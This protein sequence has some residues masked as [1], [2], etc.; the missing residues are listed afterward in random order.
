MNVVLLIGSIEEGFTYNSVLEFSKRSNLYV[1]HSNKIDAKYKIKGVKFN[2]LKN[3][4]SS[5][6]HF[7]IFGIFIQVLK[8]LFRSK[9]IFYLSRFRY[10]LNLLNSIH[11]KSKI[12]MAKL[13][14]YNLDNENVKYFS[15][16]MD[17]SAT[18]LALLK[19]R[20]KI[21]NAFSFAH[22]RDLFEWREPI[23]GLLPFKKFQLKHLDKVFSVSINGSNY[24]KKRFQKYNKKIRVFYLGSYDYG[25][26]LKKT[27]SFTLISCADIKAIKRV[28]LIADAL[29]LSKEELN[30]I[31]VGDLYYGNDKI[32]KNMIVNS[33]N[34]L[35]KN[36]K[37]NF[38]QTGS[39]DNNTFMNIYINN[40]IN[41]FINVSTTEGLPFSMIEASSFGIP[42]ISTDAGGCSEI[43]DDFGVILPIGI[44]PDKLLREILLFKNSIKNSLVNHEKIR[45]NWN[46][47][48][49]IEKNFDKLFKLINN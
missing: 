18:L 10:N 20:N 8:D 39:I 47:K 26:P 1:F 42:I 30:W 3:N 28:H 27:S 37:I 14:S 12:L 44:N 32:A 9:N 11:F 6:I 29:F 38:R 25:T 41:L 31:H 45:A 43:V 49:N 34:N 17:D 4:W 21:N 33:L 48:F 15:F 13:K 16:W 40:S 2:L 7:E 24:L 23:F 19:K 46:I 35:K 36:D 22:G 5:K